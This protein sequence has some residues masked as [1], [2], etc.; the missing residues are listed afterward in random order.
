[1]NEMMQA[2]MSALDAGIAVIPIVSDGTKR[3]PFKWGAYQ[4]ELPTKD[5]I[6]TWFHDGRYTGMACVC[7]VVSNNLEVLDFDDGETY[8]AFVDTAESIGLDALLN[9]IRA[10]YEESTPN[11]GIHLF[12]YCDTIGGN[13][14]LA[15]RSSRD[16]L[17]ETRGIGGY[18]IA[19]PSNGKVHPTGGAWSLVSGDVSTI[20][21]ITP[22]E[23]DQLLALARSFDQL[24]PLNDDGQRD[25]PSGPTTGGRPGDD[26]R[27]RHRNLHDFREVIEPHGWRLVYTRG[28]VGYFCRPGKDDGISASFNHADSGLFYVFSSSTAFEP[29]R[30]YNPFSVYAILNHG[31]NFADASSALSRAGYGTK[32]PSLGEITFTRKRTEKPRAAFDPTPIPDHA[33]T[34][35]FREY[36]EIVEPTTE[37][38]NAFHIASAITMVGSCIGKRVGLLHTSDKLY[39]NFYTLLIG[40]SGRSR[41]DTA[42]RRMIDMFYMPPPRGQPLIVQ[43]VPF[44]IVRDISSSEGLIALLREQSNLLLYTSEFS[45]VMSNAAREATRS[46]GPT[47]IEAFDTPPSLQNNTVANVEKKPREARDPFVSVIS[48][49]QPEILSEIIGSQ[50]Q[51]SGFLNRWLMVAGDGKGARPNPPRV[52]QDASW[53][54]I[55]RLMT[56]I[57]QYDEGTLLELDSEAEDVWADWYISSYPTG[58][59]SA[60][61]DAMGIRRGT[62]VKKVALVHAVTD[63][64]KKV[65]ANHIETGIAISDWSWDHVKRMIPTWGESKDAEMERK[66]IDRLSQRGPMTKRQLQQYVGNRLGPGIFARIIKS[67]VENGDIVVG[68]GNMVSL[69]SE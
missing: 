41:K 20:A 62:I 28:S 52:D 50:Q 4:T 68:D 40:P 35:W 6:R 38:P 22:D 55:R 24:P 44:K 67:M 16:V 46:I 63:G 18:V 1:M 53:K 7:G 31:G 58:R 2:A 11:G 30:G 56:T 3:P 57:K 42:I 9:R 39:P 27:D 21:T 61:E 59:E 17:I 49:V 36:L 26:F 37:S 29:N 65:G 14:K 13:Q 5:E 15:N 64:A 66:I 34:G 47:L 33:V 48:T 43:D 10:G 69:A 45:K 60:Q 54:L 12:Y 19:A 25:R 32:T 8:Q 23:R 51:Y